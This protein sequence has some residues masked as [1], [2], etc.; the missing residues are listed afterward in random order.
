MKIFIA[1]W[2][3]NFTTQ[4]A[5]AF[6]QDN[7]EE[8]KKIENKLVV[9]P[10]FPALTV[11]HQALQS[12]EVAIGAQ[13]VSEHQKGAF[14]GQVCAQ[15]LLQSGCSYVLVGHSEERAAT[16]MNNE[17]FAQKALRVLEAGMIPVICIGES[18]EI[19]EAGKTQEFLEEQLLPIKRTLKGAPVY[20]AYEPIWAIGTDVT[21]QIEEL[22]Q[23]YDALKTFMQGCAFFYGGSVN[24]KTI[25][26]L[27]KVEHICGYLIG[28]ASLDFQLLKKIVS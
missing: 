20:I 22:S 24:E 12:T 28:G 18:K 13:T 11:V 7:L 9:C 16:C 8:L 25:G 15:D 1:N 27:N 17:I 26:K 3:M 4:Q 6:C 14:T 21:P 2:K 10:S 5:L 19:K 23:L